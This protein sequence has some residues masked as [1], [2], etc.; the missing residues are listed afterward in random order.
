MKISTKFSRIATISAITM[1]LSGMAAG[2]GMTSNEKSTAIGATTGAVAGAVVAGPVGAVVGAGVGA[3]VGHEGT[4][5]ASNSTMRK[6]SYAMG[7]NDADVRAVQ[8]SLND[9]GYDAGAVDGRWG[10]ATSSALKKFQKSNGFRESGS[11]DSQTAAALG[12]TRP[13]S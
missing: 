7:Y 3:Y 11:L 4:K 2:Q 6:S 8:Q 9:K 1:L 10:P 13:I 5:G 12:V